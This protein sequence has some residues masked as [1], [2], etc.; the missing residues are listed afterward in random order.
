MVSKLK[1]EEKFFAAVLS[2]VSTKVAQKIPSTVSSWVSL[3]YNLILDRPETSWVVG[4]LGKN[5]CDGFIEGVFFRSLLP[6]RLETKTRVVVDKQRG[7]K[8]CD[9][10]VEGVFF[11]R[12]R[13]GRLETRG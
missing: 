10:F 9:G 7:K 4:L 1:I 2:R 8:F 13:P 6:E 5:F 11:R 12:L 3:Y